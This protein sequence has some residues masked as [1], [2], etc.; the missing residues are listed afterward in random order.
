MLMLGG[1]NCV[2]QNRRNRT[3][4]KQKAGYGARGQKWKLNVVF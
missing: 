1:I 2:F 4:E 3:V